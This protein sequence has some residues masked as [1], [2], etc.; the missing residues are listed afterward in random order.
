MAL[1]VKVAKANATRRSLLSRVKNPD[2]QESW[3]DFFRT[4]SKLVY[5]VATKAG[6]SHCEAEDVVQE[7]F[8]AL[9]KKMP[10]FKYDPALG[11]FKSFLIHT[12]QFKI[13][14]QLRKRN[15]GRLHH[16]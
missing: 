12:A 6:L 16:P 5:R 2:D 15:R 1:A 9:T 3:R 7:T 13:G 4:Y 14:D 10:Q 8:I 11:S